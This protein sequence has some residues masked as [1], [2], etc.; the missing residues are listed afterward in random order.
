MAKSLFFMMLWGKLFIQYQD[1]E[2]L[3]QE[4]VLGD[5]TPLQLFY[6]CKTAKLFRWKF[7]RLGQK[8]YASVN[9]LVKV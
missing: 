7:P 5:C 6:L 1:S 4:F 2:D 8:S 9:Y 3:S